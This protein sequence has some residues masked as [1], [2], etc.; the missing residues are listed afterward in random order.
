MSKFA[1]RLSPDRCY[2]YTLWRQWSGGD[3]PKYVVFI[4]LNP[5]TADET[6]D[7][8]TIRKC[9]GFAKLWGYE[10]LLM[11]NLFAWRDTDPTGM[12]RATDP[13]GPDNDHWLQEGTAGAGTVIAAWGS[14]GN[15]LGRAKQVLQTLI[16]VRALRLN[17]DGSPGHPLYIPY[18]AKPFKLP[19]DL[20]RLLDLSRL[21]D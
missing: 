20:T 14:H 12:K 7:D 16:R 15:H 4:G 10:A 11:L 9:V 13:V 17:Q 19:P 6:K 2:R 1:T 5:S 18:S 21:L 8:A 3:P